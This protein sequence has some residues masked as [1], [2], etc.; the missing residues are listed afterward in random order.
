MRS[1]FLAKG[2]FNL[3][4]AYEQFGETYCLHLQGRRHG[5]RQEEASQTSASPGFLEKI[6]I[7]KRRTYIK[8]YTP[9]L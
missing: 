5:R 9:L 2:Y 3:A 4:G 6:N 1:D 8:Y 7:D